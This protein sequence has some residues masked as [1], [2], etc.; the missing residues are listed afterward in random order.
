[1]KYIVH[2]TLF[3]SIALAHTTVYGADIKLTTEI[4]PTT[5]SINDR[6]TVT[7]TVSGADARKARVPVLKAN[8][9]FTILG[10]PS[11]RTEF[12]YINGV[13]HN[14]IS[15]I[16]TLI[17]KKTGTFMVGGAAVSDGSNTYVAEGVK[18]EVGGK[19]AP[20]QQQQ[21]ANIFI[22]TFVDKTNPYVG[23]QITLTFE[24]FNRSTIWGDTEYE[25][26]STTGFWTI[27][28]PKT[29][30]E[31]KSVNS[32]L[33]NYTAIKSALFPTTSGELTIG[34]ASLEFTTGGFFSANR[35]QRL[36]T[37]PLTVMVK[38]LP[39]EGKPAGFSGAVGDY[40][41]AASVNETTVKV[42]DVVT[43]TVAVSGRGNLDLVNAIVPPDLSSFKMYDP[44]VSA[45]IKNSGYIVGG[46]KT[47][48]YILMPKFQGNITI[49]PF[50]LSFFDPVTKSYQTVSTQPIKLKV[51]PG[52]LA[53]DN[54]GGSSEN[55][56]SIRK[57][58]NDIQYI[59]SDKSLLA[60]TS[61]Q[62]HTSM[63]FYL[64]YALPLAFFV[65]AFIVKRRRDTIER[66]TGLRRKLNA[67]KK[68]QKSMEA[69]LILKE[70]GDQAL[71]YGKLSETITEFI[72]DQLNIDTGA[73]TTAALG[74][75][76]VDNGASADFADI[77]LKTLEMCDFFR[78]SSSG[79]G[80]DLHEKLVSD[81]QSILNQL[82]TLP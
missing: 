9:D 42:G 5:I 80:N 78:F 6:L 44:K 34:T 66:N 69:A 12:R 36:Q 59:K 11:T 41:I 82:R 25:P 37:D 73:L 45:M 3:I 30:G 31:T 74:D 81:V 46:G 63:L 4:D 57:I 13:S 55:R 76:L 61:R 47:W 40:K 79:S 64:M 48:E 8:P 32:R 71:F 50:S 7:V 35:L 16:Y 28:L 51:S 19:K 75:I 56:N 53:E 54:Q 24:L 15:Y 14:L 62:L 65:A 27:E 68:S 67:W 49:E 38:P 72:G 33:Y 2:I 1:M 22:R 43:V 26:P 20:Q 58:A 17:P 60:N 23:E 18:V 77:T 39:Q 21:N 70:K 10:R 29:P 52:E